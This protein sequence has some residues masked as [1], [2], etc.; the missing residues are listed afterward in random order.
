M[1]NGAQLESAPGM[2]YLGTVLCADG[3]VTSEL[4]RR[5]GCAKAD[6]NS[7][8]RVWKHS[9]L[10]TRRKINIYSCLVESKLLY[11]LSS[12]CLTVAEQRRLDGFQ[13]RCLRLVLRIRPAYYS[14]VS[15]KIVLQRAGHTSA[16]SLLEQQQLAMLGKVLRAP[17][18]SLLHTT[19]VVPGTI[20]PSTS[21]YIRRRGRPR[22]EWVPT[23]LR[24]A[25]QKN[26]TSTDLFSLAQDAKAW[27]Q[28]MQRK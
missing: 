26:N 13:A 22:K 15:N 14:R 25:H 12:C 9:S 24:L 4:S 18:S 17:R 3:R 19:A 5:I 23:V 1:P 28:C 7:L 20:T 11:G 16:S 10:T 21:F 27:R 2:G 6:F 8:C